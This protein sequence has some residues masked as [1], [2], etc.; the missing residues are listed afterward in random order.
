MKMK[1]KELNGIDFEPTMK[2]RLTDAHD[3][4]HFFHYPAGC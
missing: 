3:A 4:G 2:L 1:S